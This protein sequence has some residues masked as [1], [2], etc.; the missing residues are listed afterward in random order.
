MSIQAWSWVID[1]SQH[2]GNNLLVLLM[3]A[4]ESDSD[5]V[6]HRATIRKIASLARLGERTV[7]RIISEHLESSGEL[8][9]SRWVSG[10]AVNDKPKHR[11]RIPGVIRDSY[12]S[13][14]IPGKRNFDQPAKSAGWSRRNT[15][16]ATGQLGRNQPAN[17]GGATGHSYGR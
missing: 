3:I 4:N 9:V 1:R 15:G 16:G 6:C 10:D 12:N 17:W 14:G 8:E 5:G 2:G 11:Y 13:R 7:R